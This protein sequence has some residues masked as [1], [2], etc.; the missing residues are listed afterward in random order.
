[1]LAP[2]AVFEQPK[3]RAFFFRVAVMSVQML[4]TMHLLPSARRVASVQR[5]TNTA[6]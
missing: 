2:R 5:G 4:A 1:M 3:G 6:S